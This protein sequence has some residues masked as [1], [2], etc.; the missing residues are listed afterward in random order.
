MLASNG[1]I[2]SLPLRLQLIL[3]IFQDSLA[4]VFHDFVGI[5]SFAGF[6]FCSPVFVKKFRLGFTLST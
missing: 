3:E 4:I 2:M 5:V 1:V 6:G